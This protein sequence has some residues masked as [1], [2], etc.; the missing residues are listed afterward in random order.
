MLFNNKWRWKRLA[1]RLNCLILFM[2]PTHRY[3]QQCWMPNA[4]PKIEFHC[5]GILYQRLECVCV[6]YA[7]KTNQIIR[8]RILHFLRWSDES[9]RISEKFRSSSPAGYHRNFFTV[10]SKVA[11]SFVCSKQSFLAGESPISS[12]NCKWETPL[13][14]GRK[15][16]KPF[17]N[18]ARVNLWECDFDK[19]KWE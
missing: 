12:Q 3:H 2:L 17:M 6:I 5:R 16:N 9:H 19:E 4:N 13:K 18:F 8:K 14:M 1:P 7:F 10:L 15:I 11:S